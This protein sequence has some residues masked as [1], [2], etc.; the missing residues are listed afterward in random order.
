[1]LEPLRIRDFALLWTG[2][3]V[4]IVGDFFFYVAMAWQTYQLSNHTSSL[5]WISACYT[6]PLVVSLL[7]G[8]VLTDR[9]ERRKMMIAGDL[10]RMSALGT[11][12]GLS[13]T[14]NLRLWEFGL[15]VGATGFG[16]ALFAPAFGSIIP[17]I[18]PNELLP[19]ANALEWFIRPLAGL[20][21]PALGGVVIAT[22]GAGTAL[23][24]DAG[25]FAVSTA[26]ALALSPRPL[27]RRESRS[28]FREIREGFAFV[29]RHAWLWGTLA[30]AGLM[31]VA[32]ASRNVLLPFV[33]K[34]DI[35][36]SAK[37]LGLVYSFHS[38]AALIGA[39]T[40]GQRGL[41]RRY[42]LVMYLGWG[43]GLFAIAGFGLAT[44]VP[45]LLAIAFAG[46][47]GFAYGQGIW[48]TMMQ[49]LVPR[50]VLGRV[51]SLDWM[52]SISLMPVAS[53]A[54]GFVAS[55]AGSRAT[56]VGAGLLSG[57]VTV[58]F[59]LAIPGLRRP[60]LESPGKSAEP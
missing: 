25:T 7:A 53:V 27:E 13:V 52:T 19:Q 47:L 55:A 49:R 18:V 39:F 54:V 9:F 23:L 58:L 8:G 1:M 11:A 41:P 42:V 43:G 51:T 4:S 30:A 21:G 24:V 15:L 56:L 6:A 3:T 59:L 14:G 2:M 20:V 36:G 38:A 57:V 45:Q 29:R 10:V 37:A 28:A 16:D 40:F 34:N 35:H 46:G 26:A 31:N 17:E 32:S 48:G 60:E 22:S 12:G 33:I 50:E 5:G 44:S